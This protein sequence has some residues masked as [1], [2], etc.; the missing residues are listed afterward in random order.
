[1][2]EAATEGIREKGT[3]KVQL[4]LILR[5]NDHDFEREKSDKVTFR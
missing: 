5:D 3:L 1:M 4:S 2:N